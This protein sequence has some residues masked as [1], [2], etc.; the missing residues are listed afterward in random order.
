MTTKKSHVHPPTRRHNIFFFGF[1]VFYFFWILVLD[2][3]LEGSEF[4]RVAP[5]QVNPAGR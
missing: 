3:G 5:D 2:F 4:T 1:W